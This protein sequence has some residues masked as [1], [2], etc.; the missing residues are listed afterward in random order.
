M[1]M[2]ES[3]QFEQQIPYRQSQSSA[4]K[5]RVAENIVREIPASSLTDG[6]M[7]TPGFGKPVKVRF[8]LGAKQ[9][10]TDVPVMSPK[11]RL[12]RHKRK[13]AA[14]VKMESDEELVVDEPAAEV[15]SPPSG[16]RS[17]VLRM[18]LNM[19]S[20]AGSSFGS[21]EIQDS[22]RHSVCYLL[23]F[24]YTFIVFF[25]TFMYGSVCQNCTLS[26]CAVFK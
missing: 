17:L 22:H 14:E 24:Y 21:I 9:D 1:E 2:E 19:D 15:N 16:E 5:S 3:D 25:Y 20:S 8:S 10:E 26:S 13:S 23:F 11:S 6:N 12:K 4:R 18:K 7:V